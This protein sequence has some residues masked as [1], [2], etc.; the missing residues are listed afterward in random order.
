MKYYSNKTI[1]VFIKCPQF[2]YTEYG[3]WGALPLEVRE[4]IKRL[5]DVNEELD[6]CA[7]AIAKIKDINSMSEYLNE[8]NFKDAINEVL[9]DMEADKIK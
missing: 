2:G 5:L 4:T 3:R 9:K 8:R 6:K 7:I 1:R